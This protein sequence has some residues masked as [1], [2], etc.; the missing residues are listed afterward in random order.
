MLEIVCQALGY[1]SEMLFCKSALQP[2]KNRW[3]NVSS[4]KAWGTF[5]LNAL[6]VAM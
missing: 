2:C 5:A 3:H 4:A 6:K 1:C